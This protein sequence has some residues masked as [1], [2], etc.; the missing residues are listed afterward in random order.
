MPVKS[1]IR[2]SRGLVRI[3][4]RS[5]SAAVMHIMVLHL[6]LF[7]T[8]NIDSIGPKLIKIEEIWHRGG[9]V[10]DFWEDGKPDLGGKGFKGQTKR[11][12]PL[13]G[14][15]TFFSQSSNPLPVSY[16]AGTV[17]IV[18]IPP[19]VNISPIADSL[20]RRPENRG[21]KKFFLFSRQK[22]LD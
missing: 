22:L 2:Q 14:C 6:I 5:F 19:I 20:F 18:K 10:S 16:P 21:G 12:P 17:S 4:A 11:T 1:S 9:T 7:S 15:S 8:F 3:L 13:E